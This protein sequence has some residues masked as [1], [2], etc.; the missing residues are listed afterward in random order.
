[1][2][3]MHGLKKKAIKNMGKKKVLEFGRN[4]LKN[5]PNPIHLNINSQSMVDS[6]RL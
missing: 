4:I 1:M 3:N 2:K 6:K 5:R